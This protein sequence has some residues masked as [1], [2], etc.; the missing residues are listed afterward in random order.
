MNLTRNIVTTLLARLAVLMLALVSSVVLARILG[1]E[2]RGIFA[3][4]VLLPDFATSFG[5][6]G[7]EQ[8][9][10]IYA[11]L[12]PEARRTLVW[13][14]IAT[15]SIIGIVVF[16]VGTYFL[17]LGAPGIKSLIRAPLW[18]YLLP[19]ST[20]PGRLVSEYWGAILRGMNRIFMLNIVEVAT[21]V[22]SLVFILILVGLL[23][24]DI[25]GA[26]WADWILNVGIVVLIFG[27]LR[28]VGVWGRP[29]FD[30]SLFKRTG[31]FALPAHCGNVLSWLNYKVDQFIIAAMLPPEQLGFYV[32]A[33][34]LVERIWILPGSVANALLP[35]LTNSPEH[36][37][38]LSAIIAR[39]VMFWVGVA[40]LIIFLLADVVVRVLYSSEYISSVASL[41]WLLPGIFTLAIGKVLVAEMSAR[42]K[43][44]F[45][46]WAGIA[47]VI[48]NIASNLA[49]IPRMGIAGAAL[50]ST[51][52]YSLLSAIVTWYYLRETGVRWTKLIPC[53][54]DLLPYF[55]FMRQKVLL[56]SEREKPFD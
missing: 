54:S 50:A 19:L 41:R 1:P 30:W 49:L 17:T 16:G 21:K 29:S 18:L 42:K 39:H 24:L 35:H 56:T 12:Q 14:S 31:R 45:T 9:N 44:D 4:V 8:S 51:I 5:L 20:V 34:G 28:Y 38:A 2:G 36:D 55:A 52:S 15:A 25:T 11:G 10:A 6:L 43:I 53:R 33:V 32:I 46:V 40:C 48:A 3:L 27:L 22:A 23:R 37:P 7:F 47:A 13:Q 26:V